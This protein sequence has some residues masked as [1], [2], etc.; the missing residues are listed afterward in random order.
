MLSTLN[1]LTLQNKL[2]IYVNNN[3]VL[4][5]KIKTQQNENKQINHKT[6]AGAGN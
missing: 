6:L 1:K 4:D 3:V 2:Q 5:Q